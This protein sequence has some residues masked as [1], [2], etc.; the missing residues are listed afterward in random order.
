MNTDRSKRKLTAI[1]SADVKGYSRLM[2]DD[3]DATVRTITSYRDV[4]IKLI[5]DNSGR[6]VDAKGDNLLAEFP[7][8]VDAIR[9]S[10]DIQ[11]ELKVRNEELPVLKKGIFSPID[12]FKKGI[13]NTEIINRLNIT[14]AKDY[15]IIN[16][17]AII[18]KSLKY[19]DRKI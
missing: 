5:R 3:E 15:K 13:S 2:Q 11:K 7:S 8:V 12:K 9:S 19:L 4:M 16:D 1:L 17:I 6:V 10:V 14:Y 18:I